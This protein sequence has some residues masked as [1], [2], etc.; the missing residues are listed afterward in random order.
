MIHF[1]QE[2]PPEGLELN[3]SWEKMIDSSGKILDQIMQ[4]NV[5]HETLALTGKGEFDPG[6]DR[7][8]QRILEQWLALSENIYAEIERNNPKDV[9]LTKLK[10]LKEQIQLAKKTLEQ[11]CLLFQNKFLRLVPSSTVTSSKH[12]Q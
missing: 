11:K 9:D 5:A 7:Q 8:I 6:H 2:I 4:L 3:P 12:P 1:T 10:L